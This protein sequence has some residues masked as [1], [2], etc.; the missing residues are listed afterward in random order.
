MVVPSYSRVELRP[1]EDEGTTTILQNVGKHISS[2]SAPHPS[3]L[4][5][6]ITLL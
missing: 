4:E 1:L 6:S 5:S 2:D 3:I